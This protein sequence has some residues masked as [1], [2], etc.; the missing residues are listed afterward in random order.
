MA[1]TIGR[2]HGKVALVT[3][4]SSGIGEAT[5]RA[6]LN[7]GYRVFGTSRKATDG[8]ILDG[9]EMVR[10]DVTSDASVASATQWVM[11]QSGRI[12]LLVNNAGM[13]IQGAAEESS[14]AVVH[15]LYDTN[16][17]GV[18]RMTNAVLPVMR[19]QGSGRIINLGSILGLIPS[20][21]GAHYA[22][23]KHALEGY[24][25]SLDHEVRVFGIRVVLIEPAMIKSGFEQSMAAPDRPLSVYENGRANAAQWVSDGMKVADVPATVG[26]TVVQAAGAARPHARYTSGKTAGRL[27]LLRRFAPASVFEKGLRKDM[28]LP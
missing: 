20:P 26:K 15:A 25:E 12:D 13:G 21:F 7:A 4:A 3:G 1:T 24:S 17:Y 11:T 5:A 23:T 18:V 9:I 27:A 16:V 8:A 19:K 10:C 22:A 2:A 14:I 28:R 6:L